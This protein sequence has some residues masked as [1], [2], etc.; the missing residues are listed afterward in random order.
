MQNVTLSENRYDLVVLNWVLSHLLDK[1][2]VEI[3]RKASRS[4]APGGFIFVKDNVPRRLWYYSST[5]T[6]GIHRTTP[7]L[8]HLFELAGLIEARQSQLQHKWIEGLL[9]LR[10]FALK[11]G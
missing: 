7:H 6:F 5:P 10:M 3:L 4:L 11:K 9:S 8:L 2:V 1:E